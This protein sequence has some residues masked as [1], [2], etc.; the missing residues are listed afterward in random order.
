LEVLVVGDKNVI[1]MVKYNSLLD[2]IYKYID[3][4]ESLLKVVYNVDYKVVII[5][6]DEWGYE[7]DNYVNTIRNGG[8][9]SYINEDND[10]QNLNCIS[11]KNFD[12]VTK[13]LGDDVIVYK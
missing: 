2:R 4:F 3:E 9:Y 1:L 6:S 8:K 11:N 10:V 13:L 12:K 5:D 7:K